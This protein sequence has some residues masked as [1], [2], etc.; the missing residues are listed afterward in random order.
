MEK[1]KFHLPDYVGHG[2]MNLIV[3]NL[4][5][6]SPDLFYPN[7]E[8]GSVYGSFGSAIWNGGRVVL[9]PQQMKQEIES[10]YKSFN[11]LGIPLRH[12]F[13][14]KLI[15]G[16]LVYDRYCNLIMEL[17]HDG[18]NEVLVNTDDLERYIRETYPKY[19][20]ISSTTKR[21]KG[22]DALLEE[23][24]KDY[25]LVVL[26]YALN[27]DPRIFELEHKERYEILINAYCCDDCPVRSVHYLEMAKDQLAFG[28]GNP[29]KEPRPCQYIGDDFYTAL[30]NRKSILR[31]DEL[32][33]YY[34]E[35]GFENFKIEGRTA[36]A[37]DVLE[38]YMYY[39]VKPEYRDKVRLNIWRQ[40]LL[41]PRQDHPV[42]ES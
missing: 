31:V 17:G 10:V 21:I 36:N 27:R 14:N 8:I 37:A 15:T 32:Y 19:P 12:T 23:S 24:S 5:K 6:T 9:G 11:E 34:A 30:E 35:C 29:G 39:M 16:N 4:L 33:D 20:I 7:I 13:T 41:P 1:I 2:R 18:F 22:F 42:Q 40:L 38:S 25:K 26:D 28:D 3:A